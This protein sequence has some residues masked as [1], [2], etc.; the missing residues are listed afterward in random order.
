[1]LTAQKS[2][3]SNPKFQFCSAFLFT[4]TRLPP[5]RP[6]T[7]ILIRQHGFPE[8]ASH[9]Q[10]VSHHHHRRLG[11]DRNADTVG[12]LAGVA[13]A[14]KDSAGANSIHTLLIV[15]L[16]LSGRDTWLLRMYDQVVGGDRNV[17][18]T[19]PLDWVHKKDAGT[20]LTDHPWAIEPSPAEN[21]AVLQFFA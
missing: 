1:M 2:R 21:A 9:R 17:T 8:E 12:L 3:N 13:C 4:T 18:D 6:R 15:I 20:H 5:P 16:L 11:R 14:S 10:D 19:C 7:P